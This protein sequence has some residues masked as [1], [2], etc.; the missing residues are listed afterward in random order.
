MNCIGP[1]ARSQRESPSSRPPSVSRIAAV[2]PPSRTGPNTGGT[3]R[4]ALSSERPASDPDSTCPIAASR[5]TGRWHAG[6]APATACRYAAS[7]T[8]GTDH[9]FDAS[10]V[11]RPTALPAN[12]FGGDG[13]SSGT[14]VTDAGGSSV[15]AGSAVAAVVSLSLSGLCEGATGSTEPTSSTSTAATDGAGA[16]SRR[17]LRLG[18][19]RLLTSCSAGLTQPVGRPAGRRY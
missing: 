19:G 5:L 7:N 15:G 3:A 18:D 12:G 14:S 16:S 11:W 4:W 2:S 6:G 8:S 1:T 13:A 9:E 17:G 10:T